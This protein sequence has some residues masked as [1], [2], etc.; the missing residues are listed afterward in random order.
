M[1]VAA[2]EMA[3]PGAPEGRRVIGRLQ[4]GIGNVHR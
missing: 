2:G 1:V 3:R 4:D